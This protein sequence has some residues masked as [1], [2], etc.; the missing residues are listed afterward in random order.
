MQMKL[1]NINSRQFSIYLINAVFYA[2]FEVKLMM[3]CLVPA[4]RAVVSNQIPH[5]A[6]F[7]F[8]C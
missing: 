7:S 6:Y 5:S 8:L 1:T 2:A 3:K 4:W